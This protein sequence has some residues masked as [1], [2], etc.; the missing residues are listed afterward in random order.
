M[1]I[2]LTLVNKTLPGKVPRRVRPDL[3]RRRRF[4]FRRRRRPRADGKEQEGRWHVAVRIRA[5]RGQLDKKDS[6]MHL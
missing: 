3:S 4:P 6:E 5:Q 2:D 1:A